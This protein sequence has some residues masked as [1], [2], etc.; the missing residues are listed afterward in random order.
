MTDA[1]LRLLGR[2]MA[3]LWIAAVAVVSVQATVHHTN[4]FETFRTSWFNLIAGRDLYGLN[5]QH[6]DYFKYSPTF[7][8]LFAPFALVPFG[9]GVFAWNAV[10][11]GILYWALGRVLDADRALTARAIVFLDAIGSMQNVQS[12]ALSAGL[13]IL[14]LAELDRRRE[15]RAA[16]AVSLGTVIK[17]FPIVAA[18]FSMF[19]P[20]RLP[21]FALMGVLTGLALIAAPLVV[22]SPAELLEQYRS[23]GALSRT[24]A[25]TRGY[26]VMEQ[27]HLWNGADW[28]NW[29]VQLAGAAI[30]VAPLGR[31]SLWGLPR[32]RLLFLA[33]VLMF[34]VLFN[35]K[36]ESPTFVV[37]VAGV[38]IW[39]VLARKDWFTW[40]AFAITMVGTVLSS[41]D[42]MPEALQEGFFEPYR[43]KTI[44]VLVTW[45]IAQWELWRR[46]GR[47]SVWHPVS[48]A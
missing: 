31:L 10:N 36:A 48:S 28:P 16:L 4:N 42:V 39:F 23:W 5:A 33:S 46:D 2:G 30:L 13:I 44:P 7:A 12:N 43:F 15:F 8:L 6:I 47:A 18:L 3:V 29:P 17:I 21:R 26:S 25:M 19:R 1:R 22:I 45:L 27:I 34:C 24:D 38:A 11:A 41:S 9:V 14:T 40:T 32:F 20:Y 37:A 35:H